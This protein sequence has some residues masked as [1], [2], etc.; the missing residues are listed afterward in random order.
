MILYSFCPNLGRV[1]GVDM[2]LS[3]LI[4]GG[5]LRGAGVTNDLSGI[6][7]LAVEAA[8]AIVAGAGVQLALGAQ[9]FVVQVVALEVADHST[10]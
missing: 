8:V 3:V 5:L 1:I 10:I 2:R 9:H 7:L 4:V 6:A